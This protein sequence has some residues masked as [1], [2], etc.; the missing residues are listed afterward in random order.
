MKTIIITGANHGLGFEA[1]KKIA[2]NSKDFNI[3]LACRNPERAE[4]AKNTIINET[5]NPNVSV[6][7]LD[8]SSIKSVREFVEN[9]RK[10]N[11]NPIDTLVCNAAM[12][13]DLNTTRQMS[14]DGFDIIF[15]TNH[16]GH[17]LLC[18]LLLPFMD[19]HGKIIVV[20]SDM[21]D[22]PVKEGEKFEWIGVEPIAHPNDEM[23]VNRVRYSYSKLCN[24]YFVYEFLKILKAKNSEVTVNAFNPGLMKTHF[25]EEQAQFFEFVRIHAPHRYGD[26]EKSS[27]ALAELVY[28]DIIQTSGNYYDRSTSA[29][30]T[31]EL[32]YNEKN[33]KE[34]W[35]KSAEYT[36]LNS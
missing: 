13:G 4:N 8:T 31:S 7:I 9:Y 11:A 28:S 21:H 3:V 1:A 20:A 29:V 17:F 2:A 23:A 18:N 16:L 32:S 25:K 22:P 26:L 10:N 6:M 14:E 27:T 12:V 15:A 33:A 24:V 30:K 19:K 5:G 36:Q 34:L 35:D